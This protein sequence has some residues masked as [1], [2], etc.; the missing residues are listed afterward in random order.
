[1]RRR[2]RLSP[3]VVAA[4][5]AGVA[6][7]GALLV[8]ALKPR[9]FYTGANGVRPLSLIATVPQGKHVCANGVRIPAETARMQL[10]LGA[11][12][13]P[14]EAL[15]RLRDGDRDLRRTTVPVANYATVVAE[16]APIEDAVTV[17]VCIRGIGDDVVVGGAAGLQS[18][19]Q[20]MV[21][22]GKPLDARLSMRYLPVEGAQRSLAS[23]WAA[24][25]RRAAL[26]RPGFVTPAVL[27]GVMLFL[28]PVALVAAV[29]GAVAG[30][31]GR[32]AVVLVAVVA[33][34]SGGSW[35]VITLPFDSPDESEH[36]AYVQSVAERHQRPDSSPTAQGTYAT[37]QTLALEAL[38]HPTRIGGADTRPPWT[39]AA[40]D[41][42][43]ER[44][45][46]KLPLD[47]GGG[48][49]D[50]TR[51][52]LPAYYSLLVPAYS[53]GG[54]SVFA[55]LTWARLFS[56]L[57]GLVVALAAYG[58]VR[59]V[60][61]RRPDLA[62][63]SGLL[64]ALQPMFSF[65]AGSVNNDMGV[66]AAAAVAVYL[67]VRLLRRGTPV[68]AVGFGCA[69][70]VAPIMK[71]TGLALIPPAV[72]VLVGY[73][74]R[75]PGWRQVALAIGGTAFAYV[76]VGT[77]VRG[78]LTGAIGQGASGPVVGEGA[79]GAG[80]LS[81][82]GGKL[83][84]TWQVVFP[85]LPFMQ[86]HFLM[87]WPFWDIYVIRGWGAFGWYSFVF[88]RMVFVAIL[89][90]GTV[91]LAAGIAALW[92]ERKRFRA[93]MWEIAYLVAVPIAV[94]TAISFAYYTDEA[95]AIP[96]E[97]GRY[98]FTA[99][100]PLSALASLSLLGFPRRW[101]APITVVLVVG[102]AALAYLGR[103]TYLVD[104]FT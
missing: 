60:A 57:F 1:M 61:P 54:E 23:Q 35:A 99:A 5:V 17:D 6:A 38:R 78:A 31:R 10:V 84:Y 93:W 26:F 30:F 64:V 47:N 43:R 68:V 13:R 2:A 24:V 19:D 102:M 45:A 53:V 40:R 100:A 95:R 69:L 4:V 22:A 7:V 70:A 76:G 37:A 33:L 18:N 101:Q 27:W 92:R 20:P 55:Q 94:F 3:A 39:E 77:L 62:L 15:I 56:V 44:E 58:I 83:S 21:L 87:S 41:R 49:A 81:P 25:M 14:A 59:E 88:P 51:L 73:A 80:I 63:L 34:V 98:L 82:L 75:R 46:E 67:G 50:A 79:V 71:G 36:F 48:Y 66:N 91:L 85:K 32:K 11:V 104:V 9:D 28:L 72:I 103:M 12:S 42:Y 96:G 74:F 65:M 52:H 16:F 29:V 90:V 97:Q 8:F 89:V 86:D